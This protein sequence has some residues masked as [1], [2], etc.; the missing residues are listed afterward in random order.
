[1]ERRANLAR[2]ALEDGQVAEAYAI[3]AN[4][5]GSAGAD[6]ADTEWVAGFIALTR[7]DDRTRRRAFRAFPRGRG[8]P[9]SL[10]R[11]GYWLGRANEA[12]GDAEAA[13]AAYG[14]GAEHQTSFYGQ[15]AA[16]KIGLPPDPRLTGGR[17]RPDWK[18]APFMRAGVVQA[19]YFLHLADDAARA[20]MFFRHAAGASRRRC[21]PRS[22]RWRSTSAGRRSGSGSPRMRRPTA[23]A[24]GAILSAAPDR[25][26]RV[27]GADR[28]RDGDRPAGVGVRRGRWERRR[29]PRPDAADA[30][31]GAST[32]PRSP[33]SPTSRRG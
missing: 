2:Q 23:R 3:A 24:A 31:D 22:R 11:A 17:R 12:A 6:Y 29:R 20:A 30:G 27:A 28:V 10:G 15:L 32:W 16:A 25:G 4:N 18:R 21:G 19:A 5:F 26:G 14:A 33:A 7:L 1:M 9:I 8:D 13:R